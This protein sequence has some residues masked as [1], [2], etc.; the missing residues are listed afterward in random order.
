MNSPASPPVRLSSSPM[1][2]PASPPEAA[3]AILLGDDYANLLA[4][5]TVLHKLA[6]AIMDRCYSHGISML[7]VASP[8]NAR[9]C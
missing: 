9:P 3:N 8:A 1:P 2:W 6:V 7:P 4:A 5:Q